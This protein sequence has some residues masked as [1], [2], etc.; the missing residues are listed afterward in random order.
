MSKKDSRG[1]LIFPR[2]VNF[3]KENRTKEQAIE[4]FESRIKDSYEVYS[5]FKQ[6]FIERD[7]PVCGNNDN[8]NLPK[9][10]NRYEV[11]E[12]LFCTTKFVSPCPGLDALTYYYNECNCNGLFGNLLRSRNKSGN[13]IISER[14]EFILN[15]IDEYFKDSDL[16]RILE[17]GCGSGV[18]LSEIKEGIRSKFP[19]KKFLLHGIDIDATAIQ[20]SVDSEI[21]LSAESAE[22]YV[23]NTKEKYDLVLHFELIEHLQNPYDF[24][25]SVKNLLNQ[26][27]LHHFHTPNANGFDNIAIGY[28]EFRPLAHGIFP[29]MH[30]QSFTPMNIVHFSLRTGFKV[31]QV[32]TPGNFDID[33][34]RN[35]L[36]GA[37]P[38]FKSIALIPED[39][40]AIFQ[41]WL[42]KLN[43]SSHL[44]VTLRV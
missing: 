7:C 35:F 23:A 34:V 36:S 15:L 44:R 31:I 5:K 13:I 11:K 1:E 32:D 30:L 29:P 3:L 42:K 22:S 33:I 2:Y 40:L 19:D 28:N 16:I 17:I 26:N 20:K 14:I 8:R 10:H 21:Y 25:I 43:S 6:N 37:D 24:M 27:G 4:I 18:F 12:C 9:F 39:Y 38:Y 41:N